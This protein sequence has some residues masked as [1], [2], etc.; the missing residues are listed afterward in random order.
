MSNIFINR[1]RSQGN[2]YGP[3]YNYKIKTHDDF[4]NE[5]KKM[6]NTIGDTF[7]KRSERY[8]ENPDYSPKHVGM[9]WTVVDAS[10][11][12]K[13]NSS[14]MNWNNTT[15][16]DNTMPLH[17]AYRVYEDANLSAEQ[18]QNNYSGPHKVDTKYNSN[19]FNTYKNSGGVGNTEL[20]QT[21]DRLQER[22]RR[23]QEIKGTLTLN[24]GNA[25]G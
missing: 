12:V 10:D 14:I 8:R 22:L 5:R 19:G 2:Y 21:I 18:R 25:Y 1:N 16:M 20:T 17:K 15:V 3:T 23:A 7:F 13:P 24:N 6:S 9:P 4:W 11:Y